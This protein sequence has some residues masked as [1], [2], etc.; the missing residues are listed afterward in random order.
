MFNLDKMD[1]VIN[2][3]IDKKIPTIWRKNIP[4]VVKN[5]RI[6]WIVGFPPADWAKVTQNT[7][8]IVNLRYL[9]N[10]TN[11]SPVF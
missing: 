11:E 5:D 6:V 9:I 2:L 1:D 4:I 10:D 8:K 3:M 7:T